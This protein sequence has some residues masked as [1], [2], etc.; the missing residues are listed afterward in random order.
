[1]YRDP[2]G[3]LIGDYQGIRVVKG[4]YGRI[5]TITIPGSF[6]RPQGF[7]TDSIFVH[8]FNLRID[9]PYEVVNGNVVISL[10]GSTMAENFLANII[11]ELFEKFPSEYGDTNYVS[12]IGK[13]GIFL[14]PYWQNQLKMHLLGRTADIELLSL[15]DGDKQLINLR[16]PRRA[17]IDYVNKKCREEQMLVRMIDQHLNISNLPN[18]IVTDYEGLQQRQFT[19]NGNPW[20]IATTTGEHAFAVVVD[21]SQQKLFV[22]NPAGRCD[23]FDRILNLLKAKTNINDVEWANICPLTREG[24]IDIQDTCTADAY[25]LV[26]MMSKNQPLSAGCLNGQPLKTEKYAWDALN[27]SSPILKDVNELYQLFMMQT[28]MT[29][30]IL[31]TRQVDLSFA[32][33]NRS[34]GNILD[35]N[36]KQRAEIQRFVISCYEKSIGEDIPVK[37][38]ELLCSQLPKTSAKESFFSSQL[39]EPVITLEAKLNELSVAYET[40]MVDL[41]LGTSW[42]KRELEAKFNGFSEM[43]KQVLTTFKDKQD[44][45]NGFV[46][47][48]YQ[49]TLADEGTNAVI[50]EH[51]QG[52]VDKKNG[53]RCTIC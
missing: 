9:A 23:N 22:A 52:L 2:N 25:V 6:L 51:I 20:Y 31:T 21:F 50:K 1:M 11:G 35:A 24:S 28:T 32:E 46:A 48:L 8:A 43:K 39:K 17:F 26:D 44:D 4:E 42:T 40:L 29:E 14:R 34:L 49:Q 18:F 37:V 41:G 33:F 10:N 53:S 36:P 12:D 16:I 45:I 38:K 47:N 13:L 3:L 27:E 30:D 19:D 7:Q 15:K 5:Q